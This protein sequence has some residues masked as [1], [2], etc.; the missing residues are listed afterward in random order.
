MNLVIWLDLLL[1][2]LIRILMGYWSGSVGSHSL[3]CETHYG[4]IFVELSLLIEIGI[5]Y[6]TNCEIHATN[7]R[8]RKSLLIKA[9]L[10]FLEIFF[11]SVPQLF[12]MNKYPIKRSVVF[13]DKER[14]KALFI[15]EMSDA[16]RISSFP[17]HQ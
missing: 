7:A 2:H 12:S 9:F 8:K 1:D 17:N 15:N 5:I 16:S 11:C 4:C 3:F 14:C 6:F 13:I 10:Y